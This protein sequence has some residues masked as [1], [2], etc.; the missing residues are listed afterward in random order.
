MTQWVCATPKHVLRLL[1]LCLLKQKSG[2]FF[3]VFIYS[4]EESFLNGVTNTTNPITII[5]F[6]FVPL[7]CVHI[8]FWVLFWTF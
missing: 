2:L 6:I 7:S 1:V 8:A 3:N 4:V 5:F